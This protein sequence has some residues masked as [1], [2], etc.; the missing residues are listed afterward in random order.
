MGYYDDHKNAVGVLLTR[1]AT[2]ASQIKGVSMTLYM[3]GIHYIFLT[4][5]NGHSIQLLSV[6]ITETLVGK[7]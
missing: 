5:L 7:S 1:L 3:F 6:C 4:I 2:D